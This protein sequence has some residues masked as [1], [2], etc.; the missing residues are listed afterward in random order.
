MPCRFPC[1]AGP[2]AGAGSAPPPGR[3]RGAIAARST[4]SMPG[5]PPLALSLGG[6]LASR[7]KRM[8]DRARKCAEKRRCRRENA[9]GASLAGSRSQLPAEAARRRLGGAAVSAGSGACL[10][11]GARRPPRPVPGVAPGAEALAFGE[12]TELP[13]RARHLALGKDGVFERLGSTL[14]G[15]PAQLAGRLSQPV[16]QPATLRLGAVDE[17]QRPP[18]IPAPE[19]RPSEEP[20][21]GRGPHSRLWVRGIAARL[22]RSGGSGAHTLQGTERRRV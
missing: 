15:H 1:C 7:R 21:A 20:P 9:K 17:L 2:R 4:A 5:C 3:A 10:P 13:S 8:P 16:R 22:V 14:L 6:D 19:R 18:Y 11:P 12:A